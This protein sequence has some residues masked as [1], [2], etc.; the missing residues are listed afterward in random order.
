M[1]FVLLLRSLIASRL[2]RCRGRLN[3]RYRR[4][5]PRGYYY[6]STKEVNMQHACPGGW[7]V[8]TV[9]KPARQ[10]D[11][12][13][14]ASNEGGAHGQVSTLWRQDGCLEAVLRARRPVPGRLG[15][16]PPPCTPEGILENLG[17]LGLLVEFAPFFLGDAVCVCV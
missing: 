9:V 15:R 7:F 2:L 6:T 11:R 16:H 12:K 14:Q 3:I 17:G 1:Q 13:A 4:V 5:C 8:Q 10:V